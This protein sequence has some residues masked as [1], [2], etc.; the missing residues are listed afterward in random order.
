[1]PLARRRSP[2]DSRSGKT[3]HV[4]GVSNGMGLVKVFPVGSG[5]NRREANKRANRLPAGVKVSLCKP[6]RLGECE[7]KTRKQFA[8]PCQRLPKD[9]QCMG[10]LL[11]LKSMRYKRLQSTDDG[12]TMLQRYQ[13]YTP[14]AASDH[15]LKRS[16]R[17]S[18]RK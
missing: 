6:S 5:S 1:M 17:N 14:C 8:D 11:T 18:N 10:D 13:G 2:D 7:E 16:H 15:R 9:Y 12:I 4:R 3:P